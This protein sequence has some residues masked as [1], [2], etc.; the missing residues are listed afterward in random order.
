MRIYQKIKQLKKKHNL[1]K[2]IFNSFVSLGN[3]Y[4]AM[5]DSINTIEHYEL[6]LDYAKKEND[7]KLTLQ[8]MNVIAGYFFSCKKNEEALSKYNELSLLYKNEPEKRSYMYLAIGSIYLRQ[9][10]I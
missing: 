2:S 5:N 10:K 1:R 7:S 4:D 9:K 8:A 3:C 6:A